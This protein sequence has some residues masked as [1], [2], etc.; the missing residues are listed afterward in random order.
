MRIRALDVILICAGLLVITAVTTYANASEDTRQ[1]T[2][3]GLVRFF[4]YFYED[5]T[6]TSF[7]DTWD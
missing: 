7:R 1:K 6:G 2:V 5:M 4:R 3:K